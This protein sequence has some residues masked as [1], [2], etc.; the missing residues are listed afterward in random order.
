MIEY[1]EES[2]I[3][4]W[5]SSGREEL[6]AEHAKLF[7]SGKDEF[8]EKFELDLSS[9]WEL[10][11]VGQL[12]IVTA[13]QDGQLVGY[14]IMGLHHNKHYKNMLVGYEDSYFVSEKLGFARGRV[15][16]DLILNSMLRAKSKGIQKVFFMSDDRQ[17]T[18]RLL[19][20]VGLKRSSE[21]FEGDLKELAG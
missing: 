3:E 12:Q 6:I 17:P 2:G 14:C 4:F 9:Y 16:V 5:S 10:D 20:F 19:K 13:R 7:D 11:S 21:I 1:R 8:E 18:D 15:M